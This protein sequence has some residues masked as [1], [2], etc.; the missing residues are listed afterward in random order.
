ME[1]RLAEFIRAHIEPILQDW[2]AFA[3]TILHAR[4]M[5]K[6]G[7]RDHA[8]LMLL[9]VAD[10]LDSHQ[11]EREQAAKSKGQGPVKET[12]TWAEVHGGDRHTSGFSVMETVS[13]FRALRASVVAHWTRAYPTV[14]GQQL[15]GLT[16]FHEAIDQA[17]AESLEHYTT[18]KEMETRLF[19]AVLVASPDPICVLNAEGTFIYANDATTDLLALEPGT[20]I[21]KSVFDLGFSFAAQ[22]QRRLQKV[23]S[24]KSTYRGKLVHTFASG[25]GERFEYLLAPVLDD[26][27][28]TEATVCMFR[29][30]TEQALAEEKIW[31]NAHH[32]LLTGLPNRRLFLD[33]LEQEVKHA[34][35]SG[36]PLAVL[37][38]DLD[39]F[40]DVNDSLGHEAGDRVL[41]DVAGRLSGCV[42]EDDTV[43]RLGGDEF[44]MILTGAR[45]QSDVSHVAR[46]IFDALALPF[47][48]G[49]RPVHISVS[50]GVSFYPGDADTPVA[51]LEAAD[52]A[53]YRAKQSGPNQTCFYQAAARAVV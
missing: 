22:F 42:R 39:G 18:A 11:S 30:I 8:R 50:I 51:L 47:R 5:D 2:E 14:A 23:T 25:Q 10:D 29:D 17:V 12:E 37:F 44:T 3:R 19:G 15:E 34:K 35:R 33:R 26:D 38:M 9:E 28:N 46:L 32:D 20:I 43:A 24:G 27:G 4:R 48:T 52:Q 36:L 1:I 21:G 6:S 49:P 7:L 40:K 53:M 31:H 41:C 45:H 13:E 16:R